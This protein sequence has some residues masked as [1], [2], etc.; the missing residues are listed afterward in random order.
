MDRAWAWADSAWQIL[1]PEQRASQLLILKAP[2]TPDTSLQNSFIAQVDSLQPGGIFFGISDH[3]SQRMITWKALRVSKLPP[4]IAMDLNPAW[5]QHK[6]FPSWQSAGAVQVDT[7]IRD[8]GRSLGSECERMAVN[9]ALSPLG[10]LQTSQDLSLVSMG[11]D[12]DSL[13]KKAA[14]FFNGFRKSGVLLAANPDP[15]NWPWDSSYAAPQLNKRPEQILLDHLSPTETL[16]EEGLP[17]IQISN[18]NLPLLDSSHAAPFSASVAGFMLPRA[19]HFEGLILSPDF[20]D[21]LNRSVYQ[22][23]G[24]AEA[25]AFTA[26]SHLIFSGANSKKARDQILA[27][28]EQGM[29]P[30][31]V[32]EERVKRVLFEKALRD[33]AS[34]QPPHP[35]SV[36]IVEDDPWQRVRSRQVREASFTLLRD[37]LKR[38]PLRRVETSKLASLSFGP[39]K[40]SRF[41]QYLEKYLG[42]SNYI[43][44]AD[45]SEAVLTAQLKRLRAFDYV[46]VALHEPLS[47]GDSLSQKVKTFIADLEKETRVVWI[48]FGSMQVL[49]D[50]DSLNC[51]IQ[52]YE[53]RPESQ[54]LAAQM[55]MGGIRPNGALPFSISPKFP[56]GSGIRQEQKPLR[57]K[58]SLPEEVG[59]ASADLEKI[60]SIVYNSIRLGVFPGCQVFAAKKGKVFFNKAYGYHTYDRHRRVSI[61]DIY[62]VA[63]ITKVAATT[64]AAMYSYEMDSLH[65]SDSLRMYI[66]EFDSAHIP[67]RHAKVSDILTHRAGLPPGMPTYDIMCRVDSVDSLKYICFARVNDSIHEIEVAKDLYFNPNFIDTIMSRISH[68]RPYD[69]GGYKYSDLGFF[70]MKELLEHE[71][72]NKLNVLVNRWYYKPLGL[73]TT[74]F[75]PLNYFDDDRIIPTENDRWFRKQ[76]VHGHVHDPNAALLGGVSGH[77]GLFSNAQDLGILLQMLLNGGQYGG[78]RFLSRSTVNLFTN[79]YGGSHRG[80]GFDKPVKSR[81]GIYASTVSDRLFG[82]TGFTG[83]C[84]WA[85]PEHDIVYVF[86]SNRVYPKSSNKK[87]LRYRVRQNVMQVFY[88][89]LGIGIEKE[90]EIVAPEMA[91]DSL[92]SDSAA[93]LST[94]D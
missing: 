31:S 40:K 43:L 69:V 55:I 80:L 16:I 61:D 64:L 63:S 37:S 85:D 93:P 71:H 32:F 6:N 45:A 76:Q 79:P 2:N 15:G 18:L 38:I 66:E 20:S 90:E 92:V 25:R 28:V 42:F 34:S 65:I 24:K 8:W 22:E 49:P 78:R 59:I 75:L 82:H 62:D 17:G 84:F 87:I 50:L 46:L 94:V 68:I 72:E 39:G 13:G 56:A 23:E 54:I 51:L 36:L 88:D 9:L 27:A 48:N 70:L 14:L 29:V 53:D 67:L 47:Q 52:V 10:A 1:S 57:F 12:P 41:Q 5:L 33:L 89:A 73:Q 19:L 26:G 86:L 30:D 11:S 58:Y 83:T 60:D 21:S 35:D 74:S 81:R 44:K 4:W 77:A 7:L 3:E 91:G